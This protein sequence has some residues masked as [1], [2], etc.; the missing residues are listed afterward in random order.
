MK[1]SKEE[2]LRVLEQNQ[3]IIFKICNSYCA[4]SEDRKDLAQDIVVQL[5]KS[6]AS[7]DPQY[8]ITTWLYRIALNVAISSS[9]KT[10]TRNKYSA[11]IDQSFLTLINEENTDL[12]EE[13]ELLQ[14][15]IQKLDDLSRALLL[16]WLD[17]NSYEEIAAILNISKS[18]VGTKLGRIKNQLKKQFEDADS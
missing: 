18:N 8:K 14:R 16:L 2:F 7:Y 3:G 15:F 17:E 1:A 13:L 4:D 10:S 12:S 5:W 6:F 9:R 11:N